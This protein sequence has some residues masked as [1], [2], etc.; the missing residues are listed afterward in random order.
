MTYDKRFVTDSFKSTLL[1]VLNK[2]ADSTEELDE[3]SAIMHVPQKD[4]KKYPGRLGGG[5]KEIKPKPA[6]KL[7]DIKHTN[8]DEEFEDE[9]E[10]TEEQVYNFLDE[11]LGPQIEYLLD[12]GFTEDEIENIVMEMLEEE[13]EELDE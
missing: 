13:A 8:E 12:E 3:A 2:G 9:E 7:S 4:P 11:E 6:K 5:K 10:L 1:D